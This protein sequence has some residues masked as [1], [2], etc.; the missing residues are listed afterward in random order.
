MAV[1]A[2]DYPQDD[3]SAAVAK[4]PIYP[5]GYLTYTEEAG[6]LYCPWDPWNYRTGGSKKLQK[7]VN[8]EALVVAYWPMSRSFGPGKPSEASTVLILYLLES[9][10]PSNRL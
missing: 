9:Y 4:F 10:F 7:R 6:T 8:A 1:Q 2:T 3:D 5:G